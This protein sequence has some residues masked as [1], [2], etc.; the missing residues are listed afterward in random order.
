[1]NT[2]VRAEA[3]A[4]VRFASWGVIVFLFALPCIAGRLTTYFIF[5]GALA[6][7][8]TPTI[9]DAFRARSSNP[10]DLLFVAAAALP[11]FAFM[12]TAEEPRDLLFA[13]NFL[14]LLLAIPFRWQLERFASVDGAAM[15]S[16]LSLAGASIALVVAFVQVVVLGLDRAGQPLMSAF[17]F[18]DTA[19]LLGFLAP[20]GLFVRGSATRTA[21]WL[22]AGPVIGTV[23]VLLSGT[24]GALLALPVLALLLFCFAFV[25]AKRR[26]FVVAI[27][28]G[29]LVL[30]AAALVVAGQLGYSRAID[31][32]FASGQAVFG[33]EVD[34]P[35][36]ERLV[37]YWGAWQAFQHSPLVGYG[38]LDMVPAIIPYVPKDMVET[39]LGFRQLHNGLISFAV[40]AG[41]PGIASFLILS[42]APLVAVLRTPR[43]PQF[44]ARLYMALTLCGG[45]AV[46][47]LT[48]IMIGFEF[49]TVQY[50][51]ITMAILSLAAQPKHGAAG[52]SVP[53]KAAVGSETAKTA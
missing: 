31:A 9:R 12:F 36:K 3:P 33:G 29:G 53:G 26:Q 50:A 22:L 34:A 47:Q 17:H 30:G 21:W 1:M 18:A 45:Y 20:A 35:T 40:G 6:A 15:I 19:L 48:I 28:L 10:I 39:M 49:H 14:P 25:Q 43:D 16:W 7:L 44:A 52:Q 8:A 51:F 5:L 27:A 24:R 37:M 2:E 11:S 32:F 23:A 41:L 4:Y 42:V 38:W 13:I 46:F